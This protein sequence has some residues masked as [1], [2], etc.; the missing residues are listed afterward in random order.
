MGC[1]GHSTTVSEAAQQPKLN[2]PELERIFDGESG[3]SPN[4][5]VK[6]ETLGWGTANL[7]VKLKSGYNLA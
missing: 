6:I 3:M 5:G 4:L 1:L 7:C 2:R